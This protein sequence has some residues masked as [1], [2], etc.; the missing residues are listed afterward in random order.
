MSAAGKRPAPRRRPR[1]RPAGRRAA[2]QLR[3]LAALAHHA[4]ALPDLLAPQSTPPGDAEARRDARRR[5]QGLAGAWLL[6]APRREG[7]A[8]LRALPA[9]EGQAAGLARRRRRS[10]R[11]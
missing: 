5:L 11:E 9:V 10:G 4:P 3:R 2:T 1:V 6:R 7:A 8:D